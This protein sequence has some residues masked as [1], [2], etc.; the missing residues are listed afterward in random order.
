M[1][2]LHNWSCVVFLRTSNK[3]YEKKRYSRLILVSKILENEIFNPKKFWLFFEQH[4]EYQ[5][6]F[7]K[8][9]LLH[10]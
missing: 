8:S 6:E 4:T 9:A 7:V 5:L 1:I 10:L 3:F 2:C